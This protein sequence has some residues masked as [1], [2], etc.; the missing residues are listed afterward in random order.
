M[1]N[2][3]T[4]RYLAAVQRFRA[5]RPAILGLAVPRYALRLAGDG[6]WGKPAEPFDVVVFAA[7]GSRTV[8]T[9]VRP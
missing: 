4:V 7:D 3:G 2:K 9:T 8:Y 5:E 1:V 6:D